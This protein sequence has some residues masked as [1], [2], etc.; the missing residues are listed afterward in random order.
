MGKSKPDSNNPYDKKQDEEIV[1]EEIVCAAEFTDGCIVPESKKPDS[2]SNT[3][4]A[5]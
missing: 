1:F 4:S 2:S 3:N 5:P